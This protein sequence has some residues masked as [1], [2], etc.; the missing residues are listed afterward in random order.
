VW[1]IDYND[2]QALEQFNSAIPDS[3]RMRA[4]LMALA[5]RMSSLRASREGM[6]P[7]FEKKN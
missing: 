2:I 3:P 1:V 5:Q 4:E 7:F 6:T